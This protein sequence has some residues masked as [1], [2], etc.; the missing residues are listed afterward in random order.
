MVGCVLVAAWLLWIAGL[1]VT[2]PRLVSQEFLGDEL[3]QGRVT[4]YRVATVEEQR[5]GLFAGPH[6]VEVRP[7]SDAHDGV[8]DGADDGRQLTVAYWVQAPVASLR[9]LDTNG[10]MSDVPAAMVGQLRTAGVPEAPPGDLWDREAA[11][12]TD[13]LGTLLLLTALAVVVLGP[14]PSRGTRWFW[15]WLLFAPLALAV[16]AFAAAELIWP[17]Y[18]PEAT[19]HPRGVAGRWTGLT[20]FAAGAGLSLLVTGAALVLRDVSPIWFIR[21]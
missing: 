5:E 7:A 16:P 6:R 12:R 9:V 18:W 17:R 10:L 1:W 19:A 13:T 15:F 21:G 4:A 14:R 11:A 3:A 20:G 8:V 2:Q